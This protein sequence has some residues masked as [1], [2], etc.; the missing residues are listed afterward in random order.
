MSLIHAC[1]GWPFVMFGDGEICRCNPIA[2][3]D[4]AAYMLDC[5]DGEEAFI[6]YHGMLY[7]HYG[8]ASPVS[9]YHVNHSIP[10]H[11]LYRTFSLSTRCEQVE[12]RAECRRSGRGYDHE[13]TGDH[14]LL[15]IHG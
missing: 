10:Y 5:I 1:P 4:L 12:S 13:T 8:G 3:S 7:M 11:H 6:D 15:C 14:S 2:E 9:S